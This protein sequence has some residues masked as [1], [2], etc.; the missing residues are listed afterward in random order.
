M[1]IPNS[2]ENNFTINPMKPLKLKKDLACLQCGKIE[3]K[4]NFIKT[5][6]NFLIH[7]MK[8]NETIKNENSDEKNND[9]N[10]NKIEIYKV[11][12]DKDEKYFYKKKQRNVPKVLKRIY[13]N[14][15]N[16]EIESMKNS[17]DSFQKKIFL[18]LNC[19]LKFSNVDPS[20]YNKKV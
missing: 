3:I 10:K 19:F 7:R 1:K 5:N 8:N 4:E 16:L 2:I 20:N 6:Y 11:N 14:L 17:V 15:T 18:C 9:M 12:S 13:P